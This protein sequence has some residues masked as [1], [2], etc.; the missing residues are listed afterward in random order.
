MNTI[1]AVARRV[2]IRTSAVRYYES[3]GILPPSRRLPNGYRVYEDDAVSS[4]R[5]IRRAQALG[6]TL[7]E[8]KQ[9]LRLAEQGKK[10]CP[11]VREL[12]RQHLREVNAKMG[13]LT[14]LRSQLYRLLRSKAVSHRRGEVCPMIER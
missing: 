3:Q 11:R 9:L 8:V 12:A 2:G 5:F 1:G 6:I 10:P 14:A 7:S 13:E 4:L